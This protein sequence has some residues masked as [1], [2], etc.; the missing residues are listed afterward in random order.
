MPRRWRSRR[1]SAARPQVAGGQRCRGAALAGSGLPSGASRSNR[2]RWRWPRH[3]SA[4]T[5]C[6]RRRCSRTLSA[7]HDVRE[8]WL[9]L[10]TVRRRLGDAAG[11]RGG[12]GRGAAAACAG[13]W[14][15]RAGR[16]DRAR[17]RRAGLVRAVG[18]RRRWWCIRRPVSIRRAVIADPDA[19][20]RG[21]GRHAGNVAVVISADGRHLLGSPIDVGAIAATVGCVQ[22]P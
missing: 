5:T 8:V 4:R 11:R 21:H 3:A 20:A 6:G 17:R 15:C 1:S 16:R 14:L 9:G 13:S 22:L 18:G 2:W 12:A 10:A 19:R 7:E